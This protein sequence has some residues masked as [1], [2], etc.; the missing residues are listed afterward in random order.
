M[1]SCVADALALIEREDFD[2]AILD[3]RLDDERVTAVADALEAFCL[4][5][6]IRAG[7]PSAMT[8]TKTAAPEA[9]PP[10]AI[11]RMLCTAMA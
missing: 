4:P 10:A 5:L 11:V 8:P 7:T 3:V 9:L 2:A 1:A 6:G